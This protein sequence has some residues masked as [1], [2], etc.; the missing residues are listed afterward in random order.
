VRIHVL[1]S[2]AGGGVPQWNC[3][4]RNCRV[5][6]RKSAGQSRQTQSSA[7]VSADGK[8]WLLLNAS[9]DLVG[10]FATFP[11]LTPPGKNLRGSAVR[12]VVLTDGE[13]DHVAGLLSLREEKCLRLICTPAVRNLLTTHFPLLP[14]LAAY[15]EIE[16][17]PFP[18]EIAGLRVSARELAVDKAPRYA[19][20]PARRGEVAGL[21]LE[22]G[23]KSL[24]YL[25]GLPAIT[26]AVREWVADCDCLL[27]DGTFW[28]DQEMI[29]P[30]LST[31]T[32]REMG[33]V[34]VGG[35]GG[36]LE[37]LRG[38]KIPRKIYTHINNTNPMWRLNSRERRMVRQAG[39]EIS[40]DG[41]EI[42]L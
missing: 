2:A 3:N 4:C 42:R 5:P 7:A 31:R 27:V 38:L 25:P 40:T 39:V 11:P 15:C 9:P 14:A 10:Q 1:G 8:E 18:V 29:T 23:G 36:S 26:P 41:M 17:S 35:A 13:M 34:P 32:A 16:H 28:T 6:R 33:H 37:W 21:R 30:G 22:A 24:V 20:R 12:A 19:R